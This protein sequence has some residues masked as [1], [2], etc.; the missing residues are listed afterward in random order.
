MTERSSDVI[1]G[2]GGMV[3][4]TLALALAQGGLKVVVCDPVPPKALL[5]AGFDGRVSALSYSSLRMFEALGVWPRLE[6]DAQPIKDILVTDAPLGGAPSPFSLHFD[7]DE[8]GR[9][10]GAIAENRHIRRALFDALDAQKNI[11]L[12]APAA[13]TGLEEAGRGIVASLSNGDK[14][15][16]SL[17]VA[18]DGRE[19]PM[20]DEM[21]L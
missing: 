9:P 20:R 17:A 21:G 7:S 4:L 14:I 16:A 1:V 8:I 3:G 6:S 5:D 10:M 13:L 18:A 11:T 2:G 19:S 12:I 15:S